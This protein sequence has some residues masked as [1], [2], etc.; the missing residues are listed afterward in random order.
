MEDRRSIIELIDRFKVPIGLSIIGLLLIGGGLVSAE[1]LKKDSAPV[2]FPKESL[3][4]NKQELQE[5]MVDVSG[6]VNK[7]GVYKLKAGDRVDDA[8]K[9]ASGLASD[10]NQEYLSKNINMAQKISDGMKIYI[11]VKGDQAP[12][13]V[14]QTGGGLVAGISSEQVSI[15]SATQ[16]EL[17]ALPG[18]G[19][20]TAAKIISARPFQKV[21]DLLNQKLVSKSVF[22]K[23][24]GM[25]TF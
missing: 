23:I 17:E 21:E 16:A 22:E 19:P 6:A 14:V 1:L 11:P 20:V 4:S 7:P 18:I 15:N 12:A 5:L 8:I 9:A 13:A 2:E 10:A 25:V 24:K 3:V